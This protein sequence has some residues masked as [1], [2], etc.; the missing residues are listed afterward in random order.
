MVM[1]AEVVQLNVCWVTV[2]VKAVAPV[3]VQK[4]FLTALFSLILALGNTVP[5][6]AVFR[7]QTLKLSV[8]LLV[9]SRQRWA[10]RSV[11]QTLDHIFARRLYW[12]ERW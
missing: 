7:I 8:E 11:S 4:G 3:A 12:S 5:T 6:L 2:V 9:W 10:R 1:L